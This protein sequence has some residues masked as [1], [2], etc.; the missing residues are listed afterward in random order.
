MANKVALI[1]NYRTL[2]IK[3]SNSILMNHNST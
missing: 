1:A 3:D 2:K